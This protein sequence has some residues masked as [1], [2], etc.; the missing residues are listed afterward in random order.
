MNLIIGGEKPAALKNVIKGSR[1]L[2]LQK[3][4]V[5]FWLFVLVLFLIPVHNVFAT[6]ADTVN[7]EQGKNSKDMIEFL[8][9]QT[10]TI[11]E[12]A[13]VLIES[14]QKDRETLINMC[15]VAL[16]YLSALATIGTMLFQRR[17]N[18]TKGELKDEI[19]D[20]YKTQ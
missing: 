10:Q 14:A 11:Q 16:T 18:Q 12:Q 13:K 8:Q 4:F 3:K 9:E 17:L 5:L 1:P 15:I 6:S 2:S 19:R 20:S 7:Q